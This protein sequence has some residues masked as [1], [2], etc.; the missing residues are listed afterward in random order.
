MWCF[1]YPQTFG[2]CV[3]VTVTCVLAH[4]PC[5]L[6]RQVC[7]QISMLLA[8]ALL[9]SLSMSFAE[10]TTILLSLLA[11]PTQ[12][13]A[14]L[15]EL[16]APSPR[17]R[18]LSRVATLQSRYQ[19]AVDI[20]ATS[21]HLAAIDAAAATSEFVRVAIA[22]RVT[23]ELQVAGTPPPERAS[24]DTDDPPSQTQ[25]LAAERVTPANRPPVWHAAAPEIIRFCQWSLFQTQTRP[26]RSPPRPLNPAIAVPGTLVRGGARPLERKARS[27]GERG[28]VCGAA[29][30]GGGAGFAPAEIFLVFGQP[31]KRPQSTPAAAAELG[32]HVAQCSYC[33]Q[34]AMQCSC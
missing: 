15:L 7:M 31:Q 13:F 5:V 11:W 4:V 6:P 33:M 18:R 27:A 19:V 30:G 25:D 28:R 17:Q 26:Q 23:E 2:E 16:S 12:S 32:P 34:H 3:T 14:S 22:L 20:F 21:P 9:V 1:S 10:T 24:A 29:G 8:W